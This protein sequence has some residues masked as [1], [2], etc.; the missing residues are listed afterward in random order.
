MELLVYVSLFVTSS[1]LFYL[2]YEILVRPKRVLK[3]TIG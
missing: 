1:F 2:F 3:R